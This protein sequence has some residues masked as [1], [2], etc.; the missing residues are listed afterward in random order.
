MRMQ[1]SINRCC[2]GCVAVVIDDQVSP[3][4]KM[5]PKVRCGRRRTHTHRPMCAR[6]YRL[7]CSFE[8]FDFWHF[9]R[10]HTPRCGPL[11]ITNSRQSC[12]HLAHHCLP[13]NF[14]CRCRH[15]NP[16]NYRHYIIYQMKITTNVRWRWWWRRSHTLRYS[17]NYLTQERSAD[18]PKLGNMP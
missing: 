9:R 1:S 8:S 10:W 6:L 13:I 16:E 12:C 15:P 14:A 17:R 3:S 5:Q 7:V 2:D 18:N 11:S 4:E